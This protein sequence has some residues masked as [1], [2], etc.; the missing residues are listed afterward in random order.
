MYK[1][2]NAGFLHVEKEVLP[3]AHD[4]NFEYGLHTLALA[5]STFAYKMKFI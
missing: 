5:F 4:L 2:S 1:H 3:Y